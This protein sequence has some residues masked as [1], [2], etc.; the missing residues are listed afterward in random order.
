[1]AQVLLAVAVTDMG[2]T[3]VHV[4]SHRVGWLWRMHAVH[5]S[6]RRFYGFNGL[7]KHPLHGALELAA[8]T[9][10]LLVLGMP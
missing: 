8:G 6:V 9:A 7:M 2:V 4:A 5:H 3:L 1:M 10:P